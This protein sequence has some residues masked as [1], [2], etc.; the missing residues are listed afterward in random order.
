MEHCVK[1]ELGLTF[2]DDGEFYMNFNKDFLNYFGEVEIV[3]KTPDSMIEQ[4]DQNCSRKYN[5][6][7]FEGAWKGESAGGCGNDT[8]SIKDFMHNIILL[9]E[10]Q[11]TL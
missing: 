3:H 10:F 2:E 6:M 5:I 1:E 11:E 8:I 9:F 7:K 4:E